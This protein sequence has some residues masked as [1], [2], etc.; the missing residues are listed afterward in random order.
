MSSIT[1]LLSVFALLVAACGS[2]PGVAVDGTWE[3]ESGT[4]AGKSIP[5]VS[6]HPITMTLDGSEIS[7]VAAC[8]QYQG[9]VD[10]SGDRFELAEVAV[11]EMACS[12]EEVMAAEAAYLAALGEAA[13]VA[14][15]EGERLVL[16]GPDVELVFRRR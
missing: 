12:P 2:G 1:T 16:R 7:G 5:V 14:A 15:V 10:V 9:R 11:T 13:T 6:D 3:L 4:S 8:N